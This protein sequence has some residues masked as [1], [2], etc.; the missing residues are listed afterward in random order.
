MLHEKQ[1][2]TMLNMQNTMNKTINKDWAV[3]GWDYMRASALESAE[4][5]EHHGWKWWKAQKLDL[6][7]LQMELVDIWHFYLSRFL[8]VHAGNE[9]KA[10]VDLQKEI[11]VNASSVKFD[12]VDYKFE[13]LGILDKL[14]LLCGL[15][16]A[17]RMS[18]G[19]FFSLCKDVGL[20]VEYIYE[21]YV[22]KNTLNIFRQAKGYKEGTYHKE[23]FGEEDNVYLVQ[24]ASTLD[25]KNIEYAQQLWAGLENTY[26]KALKAK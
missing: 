8:Q 12:E 18:V 5:I 14:D 17:K 26:E 4:A 23:W 6:P 24:I 19:L 22:Q 13:G 10:L 16:C 25:S 2:A 15:A 11:S 7:Q 1:L 9:A 20:T 3:Q 21:Q